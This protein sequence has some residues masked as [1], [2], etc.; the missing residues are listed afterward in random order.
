MKKMS[1]FTDFKNYLEN[2]YTDF[3]KEIYAKTKEYNNFS[4]DSIKVFPYDNIK[5][6]FMKS[7]RSG[8]YH[9]LQLQIFESIKE[10]RTAEVT[11]LLNYQRFINSVIE[12]YS[13]T[14]AIGI[15]ENYDYKRLF[16]LITD[17]YKK[18]LIDIEGLSKIMGSQLVYMAH[19][20]EPECETRIELTSLPEFLQY[21]QE[22][23]SFKVGNISNSLG[24]EYSYFLDIEGD[25]EED[26]STLYANFLQKYQEVK[27]A[28]FLKKLSEYYQNGI[29]IKSPEDVGKFYRLL[30]DCLIS[31]QERELLKKQVRSWV[32]D[33]R[34]TDQS[35]LREKN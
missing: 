10:K 5:E 9:R 25:L 15:V 18:G 14:Q 33:Q 6:W 8:A 22:D 13:D 28:V 12:A 23:G 27:R 19:H 20:L 29:L 24:Q 17:A 2:L 1:A 30:D 21:Y 31:G 35:R 3:D 16:F 32:H 7:F 11:E 34:I 26:L 4:I